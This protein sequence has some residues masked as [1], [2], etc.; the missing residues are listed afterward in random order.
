[1]MLLMNILERMVSDVGGKFDILKVLFFKI[2]I[3]I[4][5]LLDGF[6]LDIIINFGGIWRSDV[7]IDWSF[8][9][10]G[11]WYVLR[12]IFFMWNFKYLYLFFF[13]KEIFCYYR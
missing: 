13:K 11:F 7:I 6:I 9:S 12:L 3:V 10:L 1:M 5:R 2:M 4:R 8:F